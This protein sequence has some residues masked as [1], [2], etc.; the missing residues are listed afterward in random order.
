M[1]KDPNTIQSSNNHKK[2]RAWIRPVILIIAV[3]SL[4]IIARVF[5]FGQKIGEFRAWIE[6]LGTWGMAVFIV[7]YVAATVAAVPG[8]AI[9]VIA[10][11]L[12][13]SLL[14]VIIVSIASTTGATLCFLIARYFVRDSI[15]RMFSSNKSF[16][17]LDKL[18]DE[19]GAVIVALTRLVP[20]FPFNILNYGFGL[21]SVKFIDY[22][23]WSWLCMLPG[24]VLYV[25][26]A[27]AVTKV[28]AK[29]QIPWSL[30]GVV[31]I[32][33]VVLIVLVRHA[34]HKLK[35]KESTIKGRE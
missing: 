7:I 12:F 21:T 11:A 28:L 8:S 22:L 32:M 31:T 25:V 9:T 14:G 24:T 4:F 34:H 16:L 18:T 6:S 2:S 20:I 30:I 15:A 33:I 35:I 13:G 10:G 23:F 3:I 1:K 5:G 29:G 26:G 19:H 27:D 17:R